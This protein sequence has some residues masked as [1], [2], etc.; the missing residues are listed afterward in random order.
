MTIVEESWPPLAL[1]DWKPT[2]Q[3]LHRWTQVVGKVPLALSPF[4]NHYWHVPLHLSARGLSTSP[5]LY[6]N[7]LLD[8]EFDFVD[9]ECVLRT[10]HG[11]R[12]KLALYPRTVADFYGE[13]THALDALGVRVHIVPVPVEIAEDPIPF[14]EDTIHQDYDRSAVERLFRVLAQTQHVF[15]TFRSGF[16]GK[17]S[18]V[19]FYWGSFDLAVTRFSGRRAPQRPEADPVTRE[20]YSHELASCGFWPGAGVGD[21]AFYAYAAPEPAGY[22]AASIPVAGAFYHAGLREFLLPYREVRNSSDPGATLLSF[23]QAT[24]EAAAEFGNWDRE[25][26]ERPQPDRKRPVSPHRLGPVPEAPLHGG[27]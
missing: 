13:F 1:E 10:S 6:G 23:C 3:T 26:L 7:D 17:A 20:S 11:P 12:A 27:P 24:Y 8:I 14:D 2:Y 18:P 25:S 4:V 9:H 16:I 21:A 15:E 19:Q 5:M 22:A